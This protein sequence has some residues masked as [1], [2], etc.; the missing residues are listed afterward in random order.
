MRLSIVFAIAAA[1]IAAASVLPTLAAAMELREAIKRCDASPGCTYTL[2]KT[3]AT[4][5]GPKGGVVSCP[6]KQ[7]ACQVIRTK[8]SGGKTITVVKGANPVSVISGAPAKT[9]TPPAGPFRRVVRDH[10]G[11]SQSKNAPLKPLKFPGT[12]NGHDPGWGNYGPKKGT[13]DVTVRDHRH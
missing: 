10:R 5:F 2:D 12:R 11:Q 6:P 13:G 7:G 8:P 4:I 9:K 1:S 3:G